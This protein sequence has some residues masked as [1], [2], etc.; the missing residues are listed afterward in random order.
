MYISIL[1]AQIIYI[2]FSVYF[3]LVKAMKSMIFLATTFCTTR[4]SLKT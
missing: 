2:H 3:Q 1:H 4:G